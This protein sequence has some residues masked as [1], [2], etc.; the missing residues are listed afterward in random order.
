MADEE[1]ILVVSVHDNPE[2]FPYILV[3]G[4]LANLSALRG[5]DATAR[6]TFLEER[7]TNP[8]ALDADAPPVFCEIKAR[9]TT[10]AQNNQEEDE[11]FGDEKDNNY[12]EYDDEP[13]EPISTTPASQPIS[14]TVFVTNTQILFVTSELDDME[15]DIAV[16]G[17]CILLHALSD[18]PEPSLYLQL[19]SENDDGMTEMTIFASQENCQ[20]LFEALC[21]LIALH[22]IEGD[23]END[24]GGMMMGMLSGGMMGGGFGDDVFADYGE[25]AGEWVTADTS[26]EATKQEREAMLERLDNML[27]VAPGLEVSED[28]DGQFEDAPE[29]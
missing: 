27:V 3:R 15:A 11:V 18:D 23:D 13:V 26:T 22:P 1:N 19:Q 20:E 2:R 10:S 6:S 9:L 5:T 24:S 14:G 7:N 25:P 29:G 17:A 12:H 21:K 8:T 4:S 28:N 16:G